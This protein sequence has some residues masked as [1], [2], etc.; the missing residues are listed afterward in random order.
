MMTFSLKEMPMNW[1]KHRCWAT[2]DTYFSTPNQQYL[3][4]LASWLWNGGQAMED[5]EIIRKIEGWASQG[6]MVLM[7]LLTLKGCYIDLAFDASNNPGTFICIHKHCAFDSAIIFSMTT[8]QRGGRGSVNTMDLLCTLITLKS[9]VSES[10]Q[11]CLVQRSTGRYGRRNSSLTH[12]ALPWLHPACFQ[13][14]QDW[15]MG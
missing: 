5:P 15:L 1:I 12:L 9:S 4:P 11:I 7:V 10:S 2:L 8:W 6:R 14:A 3:Q 13:A